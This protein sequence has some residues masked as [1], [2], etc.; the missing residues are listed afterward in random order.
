MTS[1]S[2][3]YR[4][5]ALFSGIVLIGL[6]VLASA[7]AVEGVE[8]FDDG[9]YFL[10]HQLLNGILPGILLMLL[11]ANIDYHFLKKLAPVALA[12]TFCLL[13]LVLL[14]SIGVE[15]GGARRW[16][17]VF[18]LFSFQPSEIIKLSFLVY[19]AS[20]LSA[21]QAD[22]KKNH[23]IFAVFIF[24]LIAVIVLLL[25]E[26]DLGT[27]SVIVAF[28][29]TMYFTAGGKLGHLGMLIAGL[30]GGLLLMIRIEPYRFDR[31]S[32]FLHPE[33]DPQGIGYHINQALLAVGSGGIFGLGYGHSRQK[34]N[35][36][37]EV[38]SDSIF[39]IMAEELGFVLIVAIIVLLVFFFLRGLKI[40]KEAPDSFG[41]LLVIGIMSWVAFQSFAHIGANIAILP[42]TGVPL[43]FFSYGGT[44]I[45]SLFAAMGIVLNISKQAHAG[46]KRRS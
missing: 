29:L 27:L 42:L 38:T 10:K 20:W 31:F 18:G 46:I 41:R 43:P 44:A 36:L 15:F 19:L 16:I 30:I 1:S 34:Y 23:D 4:F 25:L 5:I 12:V 17:N 37:P 24:L 2:F 28:S 39:A 14:P 22:L 26:P 33:L 45:A 8:R 6:M 40:A 21:K 35:F 7:S 3:D 11:F 13:L 9:Y 32:V